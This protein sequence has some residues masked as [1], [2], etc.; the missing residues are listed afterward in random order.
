M[1]ITQLFNY[2]SRQMFAPGTALRK[3]Y[4]YFRDLLALDRFCLEKMAE[5]EEIHYRG[6]SCD[7]ARVVRLCRELDHAAGNLVKS[8]IALNPLRYRELKEYYRGISAEV[9]EIIEFEA[10]ETAPPFSIGLKRSA[11]RDPDRMPDTGLVGG[12][13]RS[14]ALIQSRGFP[15]P[16][17]FCV[18]TRAFN[19]VLS[20]N[21][22]RPQINDILSRICL[23]STESME[24]KCR[25]IRRMILEAVIP[26]DILKELEALLD[27]FSGKKLA[28]RSSAVGED[29]KLSFAGQYKSLLHVDPADFF[30]A[31]RQIL[32]G[33]YTPRAIAYRIR[34]GLPD[35]QVPMAVLVLE[36]ID[37]RESGVVY[38]SGINNSDETGI[39]IVSGTGEKLVGGEVKAKEYFIKKTKDAEFPADSPPY[40]NRLRSHALELE[41]LF[42][43]PQDIEW[44]ADVNDRLLLLQTRPLQSVS[45]DPEAPEIDLPV[46]AKGEWASPGRA[47]G[48]ILILKSKSEISEIPSGRIVVCDGLYPE[49]AAAAGSIGGVI[50]ARGSAASHFATVARESGVPVVINVS[51]AATRFENGQ[52][53]TVD[54]H[55]GII[56][57]GKAKP[58]EMH[59]AGRKTWLSDKM[60]EILEPVSRLNL[61]DASSENFAPE[62]CRSL[63]DLIRFSHE[64]G[65]REMFALA[66]RRGRGLYQ[67]KALELEIPLSF[68]VLNLEGG[69]TEEGDDLERVFLKHV[70]CE[71]FLAMFSGLAHESIEWDPDTMHFDWEEF[72]KMSA[73]VFNPANSPALSSYGLLARD[74]MHAM[75]RFGYHFAV[76]DALLVGQAEQNYIQFSF[77]GGGASESGKAMRLETIRIVLEKYG[78]TAGVRGDMLNAE[79]SRQNKDDTEKRLTV[80]GYILARTRLMDMRM[81]ENKIGAFAEDFM[82]EIDA[83]VM[84]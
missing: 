63:H 61:T 2:W 73:G 45:P 67:S 23:D 64:M 48:E 65:V 21:S 43:K 80:I 84:V 75:I 41:K 50:A 36:M 51:E 1:W 9:N 35:E 58:S 83:I 57:D 34:A 14:L 38:S 31:Y 12:K 52:T 6:I 17:G 25:D 44:V 32:A 18:T 33:K 56:H 15:V 3:K 79:Y 30:D 10:P 82:G 8:L 40:L 62:N 69:L 60:E 78:F 22:L 39:Y 66:D 54:G 68:R 16:E 53:V 19:A 7:Y 72:D 29:G 13:A 27:G 74:Y 4:Q 76:V 71:P 47:G 24:E 70:A 49:L 37:G 77:K 11:T 26:D 59:S 28:V 5:I 81:D 20:A 42:G 55:R 46:L